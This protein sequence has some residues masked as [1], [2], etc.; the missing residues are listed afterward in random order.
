VASLS[1]KNVSLKFSAHHQADVIALDDLSLEIP[2]GQFA[3]I[4]G[5]SG[6]GKSSLL[7]LLAGLKEPTSGECCIDGRLIEEPG[8]DR[9]MVFQ[10]Y[11]LFPWLTVQKNIEFGPRL[12]GMPQI[13]RGTRAKEH[14]SD[15]GLGGFE[16][17]YPNQLSGGMR[18][19]VA[20][21]RT[22]ANN[23]DVLL[24]DEP[25]GALDSQT[26]AVMQELLLD[27]WNKDQKTVLFVTH[28]I[29]EALLLGDKVFVM[30]SRPGRIIET[31]DVEVSGPRTI[32]LITSE[33]FI[34]RKKRIMAL[35]HDEVI[36][37]MQL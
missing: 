18:Q 7:Y 30:S 19:R 29:D 20:L 27:I 37:A 28:D 10:S 32:D 26:R 11:T 15:V 31:I 2:D 24:M 5:P 14:I 17:H 23:P 13:E 34:S 35:L 12:R 1:I 3:V 4:V 9:G 36:A 16:N 8:P 22:F 25:F 33:Y 6:C 21:A